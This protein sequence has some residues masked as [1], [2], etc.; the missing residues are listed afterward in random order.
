MMF[1]IEIPALFITT[2]DK[3]FVILELILVTQNEK[4]VKEKKLFNDIY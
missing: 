3:S 1:R 2:F 4:G